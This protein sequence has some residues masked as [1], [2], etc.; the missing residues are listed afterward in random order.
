MLQSVALAMPVVEQTLA[1]KLKYLSV[2][3][4]Q[5]P[6]SREG[7]RYRI[8]ERVRVGQDMGSFRRLPALFAS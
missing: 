2:D 1:L 4:S 8:D 7:M 6:G 3:G 5:K